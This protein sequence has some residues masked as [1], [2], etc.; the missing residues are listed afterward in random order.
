MGS[1]LL[2]L[3]PVTS[4]AILLP[5]LLLHHARRKLRERM[6]A[7]GQR[8]FGGSAAAKIFGGAG[9]AEEEEGSFRWAAATLLV[10]VGHGAA[11]LA[12]TF[13]AIQAGAFTAPLSSGWEVGARQ[14]SVWVAV[15]AAGIALVQAAV[16]AVVGAASGVPVMRERFFKTVM[17][18]GLLACV[19]VFVA[20]YAPLVYSAPAPS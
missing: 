4:S 14:E 12:A 6:G 19:V 20:V 16:A 18:A 2:I 7:A 1:I 15:S 17:P 8:E 5:P 9:A 11:A 10:G 13:L 3:A